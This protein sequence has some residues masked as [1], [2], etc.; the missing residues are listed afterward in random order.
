MQ[1]CK[2]QRG[3]VT[4][5]SIVTPGHRGQ[6]STSGASVLLASPLL[7]ERGHKTKTRMQTNSTLKFPLVLGCCSTWCS[8]MPRWV[9][10]LR[11]TPGA[12]TT[13][14]Q[15]RCRT[16][17]GSNPRRLQSRRKVLSSDTVLGQ[18]PLSDPMTALCM[19]C[20]MPLQFFG[21]YFYANCDEMAS[22]ECNDATINGALGLA[23][24]PQAPHG[25]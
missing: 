7:G 17:S 10:C 21:L 22:I 12:P 15:R 9:R 4:T 19:Q 20:N 16:R 25:T 6:C 3:Q 1:C 18:A 14:W 13:A 11:Q 2:G 8:P 5:Y 23:M 24:M